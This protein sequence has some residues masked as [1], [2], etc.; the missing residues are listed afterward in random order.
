[1]SIITLLTDF[2]VKDQYLASMKGVILGIN[3]HATLVDI[4]HQVTPQDIQE[5]AFLLANTYAFFP[6]ATIHLAVVDPGVGGPRKPILLVTQNH[7]F[8]GPDN[9][10]FT[11]VARREK[12]IKAVI[13]MNSNYFLPRMSNTFHGRDLFAPVAAHLSLGVKPEAFGNRVDSWVSLEVVE[14][15]AKGDVLTGEVIHI[16]AFGNLI[17]NI[18]EEQ[19]T[20]FTKRRPFSIRAGSRTIP[21]VKRGYWEGK[22]GEVI[23]LIGSGGFVEVSVREGH[24]AKALKTRRG[25][26]IKVQRIARG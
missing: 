11:F 5:G 26:P 9:G 8:V 14:P 6:K 21:G 13:L 10:L 2:G 4:T 18:Q 25:D 24:A 12:V 1:M 16:D 19:L 15:H 7:Y 3:P 20:R 17:S 22:K 23:A